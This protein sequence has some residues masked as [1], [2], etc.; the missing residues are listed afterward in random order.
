ME[1]IDGILLLQPT[2][3]FRNLSIM[4][5]TINLY[6]KNFKR[7]YVSVSNSDSKKVKYIKKNK[8]INFYKNKKR[9][10]KKYYK[11]NGSFY[12]ISLCLANIVS[13][14]NFDFESLLSAISMKLLGV[15]F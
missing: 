4:K 12:L 5:K 8:V 13:S 9:N 2:S 7:N 3:P 11:P 10:V 15:F 1:K 6:K 14:Q